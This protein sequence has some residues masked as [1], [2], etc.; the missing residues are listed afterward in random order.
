MK[1]KIVLLGDSLTFGYGVRKAES[2]A[3]KLSKNIS[4]EIINKGVNG[5]TTVGMLDRYYDDVKV[6]NPTHLLILAGTNDLLTGRSVSVVKHNISELIKESKCNIGH[7]YI[8]IP[9]CIKK[10]MACKLFGPSPFYEYCTKSLPNLRQELITLCNGNS[11]KYVDL[12]TVTKNNIS[13]NIFIDGIH[14]NSLGNSILLSC[15]LSV[16]QS[17]FK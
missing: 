5:D 16:I 8:G 4:A 17:D 9:P 7:I 14:F 11:L 6:Y 12:F 15:I 3:Y 1:S 13:N 2:W 10:E